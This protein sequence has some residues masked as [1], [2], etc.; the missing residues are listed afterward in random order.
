MTPRAAQSRWEAGDPVRVWVTE[1]PADG[2][3]NQA[4]IQVLAKALDVPKSALTIVRGEF[5]RDKVVTVAGLEE[6]DLRQRLS[7]ME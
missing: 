7:R 5:A 1:P 2:Q 4:V 6:A 3:A